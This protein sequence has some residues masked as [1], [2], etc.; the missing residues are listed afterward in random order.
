MRE[1]CRG[2]IY[3][4][5][6]IE[7]CLKNI[8][9]VTLIYSAAFLWKSMTTGNELWLWIMLS[10]FQH[11]PASPMGMQTGIYRRMILPHKEYKGNIFNHQ[12]TFSF[13]LFRNGLTLETVGTDAGQG[14]G[15]LSTCW[16]NHLLAPSRKM[17]SFPV[18]QAI[19]AWSKNPFLIPEY[20]T[21]EIKEFVSQWIDVFE[22]VQSFWN[23]YFY[24]FPQK[25]PK[26]G[27]HHH[28]APAFL[29]KMVFCF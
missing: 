3:I 14:A 26:A 28:E 6:G 22:T 7:K 2:T 17:A 23:Y 4:R 27:F 21:M 25:P 8:R 9:K 20:T 12:M 24:P 16:G 13:H 11:L 29:V 19:S 1:A 10:A 5:T 15:F 18:L